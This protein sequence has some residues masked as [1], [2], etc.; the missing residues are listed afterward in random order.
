MRIWKGRGVFLLHS[1]ISQIYSFLWN[2]EACLAISLMVFCLSSIGKSHVP[3]RIEESAAADRS[4]IRSIICQFFFCETLKPAANFSGDTL[5]AVAIKGKAMFRSEL[6]NLPRWLWPIDP[7]L[8]ALTQCHML[9]ELASFDTVSYDIW[10]CITGHLSIVEAWGRESQPL[11]SENETN[12]STVFAQFLKLRWRLKMWTWG[13]T[14][15]KSVV[16]TNPP[17]LG[18]GRLRCSSRWSGGIRVWQNPR[19]SDSWQNAGHQQHCSSKSFTEL[20]S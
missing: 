18:I 14:C 15:E 20:R 2:S 16:E 9:F 5:S 12:V 11:S 1:Q 17:F 10:T 4:I 8:E 13:D 3:L 19:P 6:R 7:S